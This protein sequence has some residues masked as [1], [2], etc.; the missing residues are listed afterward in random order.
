[1]GIDAPNMSGAN[2][3]QVIATG[4]QAALIQAGRRDNAEFQAK[5]GAAFVDKALRS[6][7]QSEGRSD[8][9]VHRQEDNAQFS[10]GDALNGNSGGNP[11]GGEEEESPDKEKSGSEHSDAPPALEALPEPFAVAERFGQEL[12]RL[13]KDA[14]TIAF[15]GMDRRLLEGLSRPDTAPKAANVYRQ[16]AILTGGAADTVRMSLEAALRESLNLVAGGGGDPDK[17]RKLLSLIRQGCRPEP[18]PGRDLSSLAG[19][20]LVRISHDQPGAVHEALGLLS[21]L[22][23][24][25][26]DWRGKVSHGML[27]PWATR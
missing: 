18:G 23:G 21:H 22:V 20:M 1:M 26:R 5:M 7:D 15:R 6:Q 8:L 3:R 16:Q 14:A 24:S 9:V 2:L 4:E 13:G 12:L 27:P 25:F 19:H 10:A 17:L 11:G